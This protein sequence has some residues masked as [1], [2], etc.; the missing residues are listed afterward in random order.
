MISIRKLIK[1]EIKRQILLRETYDPNY[2]AS[3]FAGELIDQGIFANADSAVDDIY[4]LEGPDYD[5]YDDSGISRE[6]TEEHVDL[7]VALQDLGDVAGNPAGHSIDRRRDYLR[8]KL[9]IARQITLGYMSGAIVFD[10]MG[11]MLIKEP[12]AIMIFLDKM[13]QKIG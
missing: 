2:R 13:E 5:W 12:E 6:A 3:I 4:K 8:E 11:E 10:E 1:E 9:A 7:Y